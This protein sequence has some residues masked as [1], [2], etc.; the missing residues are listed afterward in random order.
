MR[1]TISLFNT[2]FFSDSLYG[3]ANAIPDSI[4]PEEY[5]IE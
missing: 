1:V 2:V 4:W 3:N 5:G